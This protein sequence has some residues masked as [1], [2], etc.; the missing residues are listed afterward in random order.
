MRTFAQRQAQ[1][2]KPV[3]SNLARSHTATPRQQHILNI[4]LHL[5]RTIGNQAVQRMLQTH[6]NEPDVGSATSELPRFG[7]DFSRIPI[8]PPAAGAI[9]TK[10]A[11]NKPGDNYEQEADRITEQ[12][13]RMPESQFQCA[14]PCG[15][16]CPKCQTE[17]PGK[18]HESLQTKRVQASDTGQIAAPPIVHEVLR[19]PGQPLDPATRAFMEPRFG[20]DFSK[21]RVHSGATAEESA[22]DLNAHAYTVGHNVVFG[23]GRFESWTHEGRR[24][25]AHELTHVVQQAGVTSLQRQPAG[26]SRVGRILSL[27]E[28]AADPK[29]NRARNLT[30]QTTAKV[31]RSVS[32]GAGKANC[33]ATLE[34]G[35]PVTIIA[36]KAGGAWLQIITPEQVPGFGAKE[37]LYVMAAFVEEVTTAAQAPQTGGPVV[38]DIMRLDETMSI[39]GL[40]KDQ[41]NYIDHFSGRLESAPLGPD[42][43]LFP[44]TGAAS[45]TG[46]SIPKG[47]FYIDADPLS[48]FSIRQN[49]VYKSRAVA[50]AVLTDLMKQ[51]PDM[52]VYSYYLQD[53]II[54]PTTLS[55]TTIPNLMPFIRQERK[56]SLADIQATA[57]LAEALAWWYVG[58]RFPI[59]IRSGGATTGA[60]GKEAAKQLEKEAVRQAEKEA[61]KAAKE[62]AE[63]VATQHGKVVVNLGGTG[64]VANAINVNPLTAQQVKA[65]P[66]LIRAGAEEVGSLFKSGTVDK[67]VSNDVVLGTVNWSKTAEGSFSAL[68]SGGQVSIAPYAGGLAA[69]LSEIQAALKAAGFKDVKV[70]AGRIITGVKP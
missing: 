25:L 42:I 11:I 31:C 41:P 23:A 24:L 65:V 49:Q 2:Q 52:P 19:S 46:I 57:D 9:Q 48:G 6:A 15:G 22:R 12:V 47:D 55:D 35:L 40:V 28:I 37:P 56:Q 7:H 59:K 3:S 18:E 8:H 36:E 39:K 53:G 1:P 67:I 69:H 54:F 66:N 26:P 45:Q 44:K 14:C 5:Q 38:K 51:R 58:A 16:G 63:R 62:L 17:Q 34:P 68:K 30:G 20:Y 4:V 27:K 64:E 61:A 21:V 43:T 10:L 60:A 50:E 29:R 70:V 13:M 33:P 32:A